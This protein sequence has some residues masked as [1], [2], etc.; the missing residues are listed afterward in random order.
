MRR[1]VS[2]R[3]RCVVQ[4]FGY[5]Q[6]AF[7][8]PALELIKSGL[9]RRLTGDADHHRRFLDPIDLPLAAFGDS[10]VEGIGE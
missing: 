3:Q 5:F 1:S 10:V 7:A 6:G 2:F 8:A 9:E 4:V